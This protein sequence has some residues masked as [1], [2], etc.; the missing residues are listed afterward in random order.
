[1]RRISHGI[2]PRPGV[3]VATVFI[4]PRDHLRG[5]LLEREPVEALL[6]TALLQRL[7][8]ESLSDLTLLGNVLLL[9]LLER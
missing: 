1:V 4:L 7:L 2:I 3:I 8:L 9:F 5:R 6:V